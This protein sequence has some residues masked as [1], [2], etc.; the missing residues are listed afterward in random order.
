MAIRK[1]VN[2]LIFSIITMLLCFASVKAL[3]S[4]V[5]S[6]KYYSVKNY[7]DSWNSGEEPSVAEYN[8]AVSFANEAVAYQSDMAFY[9]DV[10]AEVL[11][12]GIYWGFEKN[13][14][15]TQNNVLD[16]YNESIAMRPGW[17]VTWGNQAFIKWQLQH[18][19]DDIAYDLNRANTL[20]ASTPEIHILMTRLGYSFLK[21]NLSLYV[22]F[23]KTISHRFE[24]G[25]LNHLSTRSVLQV[26]NSNQGTAIG[27]LWLKQA[28]ASD[29]A[30]RR[31]KCNR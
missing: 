18:P 8:E 12:W 4:T 15:S 25:L 27:C 30:D 7:I 13:A 11:Q 2:V 26:V 31:L 23:N 21:S 6:L 17:P 20:G 28:E 1:V 10:L 24:L 29:R 3:T 19:N 9:T 5:A 22:Q 14:D 16:L